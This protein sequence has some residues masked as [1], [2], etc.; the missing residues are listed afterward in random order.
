MKHLNSKKHT[1]NAKK[2]PFCDYYMKTQIYSKI[3]KSLSAWIS[4]QQN[5]TY[6]RKKCK[7]EFLKEYVNNMCLYTFSVNCVQFNISTL[8]A[9][10]SSKTQCYNHELILMIIQQMAVGSQLREPFH[11]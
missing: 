1:P 3:I 8:S 9:F 5:V 6:S 2:S 10:S 4:P 11:Y 7:K